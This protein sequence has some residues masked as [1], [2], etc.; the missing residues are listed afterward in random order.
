[1]DEFTRYVEVNKYDFKEAFSFLDAQVRVE[2]FVTQ[3]VKNPDIFDWMR[4]F[5]IYKKGFRSNNDN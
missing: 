4:R 1:L 2:Y 5:D 3:G